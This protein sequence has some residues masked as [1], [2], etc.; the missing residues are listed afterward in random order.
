[1]K[2]HTVT[3]SIYTTKFFGPFRV[4][5]RPVG[6]FKVDRFNRITGRIERWAL[7]AAE[8]D[9]RAMCVMVN[10]ELDRLARPCTTLREV[11]P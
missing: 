8:S 1:M 7:C 5:Q 6:D 11:L 2:K 9:A 10:R 4:G 3:F